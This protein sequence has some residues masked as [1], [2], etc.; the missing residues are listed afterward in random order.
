M[1]QEKHAFQWFPID[2]WKRK[3]TYLFFR[4]YQDPFFMLTAQIE[5][6]RAR[7]DSNTPFFLKYVHQALKVMD[8]LPAWRLRFHDQENLCLY[9]HVDAGCTVAREDGSFYFADFGYQSDLEQFVVHGQRVL[10]SQKEVPG[11]QPNDYRNDI[12]FFSVLPWV[13]FT[14]FKN[15]HREAYSDHW[16]RIV[17][18]KIKETQGRHYMPLSLEVHHSLMD[19]RD[20]GD[21]FEA[22]EERLA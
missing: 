21:F 7:K 19:G 20:L 2:P 3:G 6:S 17:S 10:A 11:L 13:H 14:A 8:E 22:L 1:A 15:P 9:D 5:V 12:A 16:P 4:D 18:G